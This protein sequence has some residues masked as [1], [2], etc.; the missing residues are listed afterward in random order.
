MIEHIL[1]GMNILEKAGKFWNWVRGRKSVPA[2]TIVTR[3][4]RLFGSHGMHRNQIPRFIGHGLTLRDVQ[5][6]TSLLAKLDEPLLE[7]VCERFA[8][9]REWLDGAE[10]QIYPYHDFYKNPEGFA[11]FIDGILANNPDAQL[12][13]VLLAPTECGE[14]FALL[15][16]QE[17][18]GHVGDKPIYRYHLCNN[19]YFEYWKARAY[20]AACIALSW[21]RGVFIHGKYLPKNEI[22]RLAMGEALLGWGG[23]GLWAIGGARWYPE[24]MALRPEAYLKG[25]D[26]ELNNFGIRSALEWW[27]EFEQHGLMD[28]PFKE[29]VR[30]LFQQEL[31]KY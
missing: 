11:K 6:D 3:F 25:V 8:V 19:W 18:T 12:Q 26:P 5:D 7:A 15:I 20:L 21:K 28:T 10:S 4:V 13:G 22:D 24:D 14:A 9:R 31:S 16:L 1:A 30:P 2:E 29:N 27:L 17:T 23:E